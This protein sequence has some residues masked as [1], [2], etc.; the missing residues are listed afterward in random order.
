MSFSEKDKKVTVTIGL[1]MSVIAVS[2][3]IGTLWE[4]NKSLYDHVSTYEKSLDDKIRAANERMK[5]EVNGLRI[6][7]DRD[8]EAQEKRLDKLENKQK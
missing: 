2:F 3:F 6:D 8:R 5:E 1:I 4:R 7:W